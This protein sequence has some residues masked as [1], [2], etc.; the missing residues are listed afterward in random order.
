MAWAYD[1][2]SPVENLDMFRQAV[3]GRSRHLAI[4]V[5]NLAFLSSFRGQYPHVESRRCG[6]GTTEIWEHVLMNAA[7][8]HFTI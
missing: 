6:A 7:I 1:V 5:G 3:L 2:N 8:S 4:G